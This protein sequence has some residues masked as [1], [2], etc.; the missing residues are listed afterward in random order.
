LLP[1]MKTF[2]SPVHREHAPKQ[3]FEQGRLA[4]AVEIP[5]RVERVRARIAERKLGPT[6][7][8]SAFD[9]AAITRV[10]DGEFVS[11]LAGAHAEW[12]A[13]YGDDAA[14]AIP[15][16]WPSRG[17]R[18]A[19]R[20]DIESRLGTY[21]FDTATPITKGTWS[22]ARA[23]VDVA[24]SAVEVVAAGEHSAFALTRPPGH[25]AS[26]DVF[27]GYCYLNNVA[28]AAQWLSDR[29][30]RPAILDVDYHHGNGTQEIFYGRSDVLF[31]SLHADPATDYPHFSGFADERGDGTG[32]DATLNLP[33][34]R[35]TAWS[36]YAE[37]LTRAS[38]AI[39]SFGADILLVSLGLDTYEYD[40]ISFFRIRTEDYLR[41]GA[42]IAKLG[43]PTLFVFE[44]GYHVEALAENTTNV[45]EGFLG[46]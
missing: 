14:D 40:P 19:R 7:A 22:A 30:L 6:L 11:F 2:Y 13:R 9:D 41:M 21:S 26:R 8:P 10:H 3:E 24:L 35:E 44:G 18:E 32:E 4:P 20:G 17:M 45:L 43:K 27:G 12:R 38:G 34:P 28:I 31:A 25:H 23:G 33:M 15:S 16:C 42:A 36:G 29:G 1:Q 5:E 46:G 37:A 39:D